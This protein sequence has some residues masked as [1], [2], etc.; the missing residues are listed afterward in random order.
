MPVIQ[1][2]FCYENFE[3]LVGL[4]AHSHGCLKHPAVIEA[5][6]LRSDLSA[7]RKEREE[8]ETD[9]RALDKNCLLLKA[10]LEAA[11]DRYREAENILRKGLDRDVDPKD[12]LHTLAT[13][14]VNG[15]FWRNKELSAANRAIQ[16][17]GKHEYMCA[18]HR[19]K[20]LGAGMRD[21][22]CGFESALTPRLEEAEK[23]M[24]GAISGNVR[25]GEQCAEMEEKLTA[26]NRA[27]EELLNDMKM[28]PVQEVPG[29]GI[30]TLISHKWIERLSALT[31]P[32]APSGEIQKAPRGDDGTVIKDEADVPKETGN[33]EKFKSDFADKL[34]ADIDATVEKLKSENQEPP[35]P[36]KGEA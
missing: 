18:S 23:K 12:T 28:N 13:L 11:E 31:P 26:A 3:G 14:A 21:C 10:N 24:R 30:F 20:W 4:K 17:Y 15:I 9:A 5:S 35:A 33:M 34:S 27:V 7:A 8:A 22:N 19:Q 29:F 32:P 16:K 6:S 1:C 2:I 36:E 25:S